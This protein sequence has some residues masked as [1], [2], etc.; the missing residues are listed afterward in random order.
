MEGWWAAEL[1]VGGG[2][3]DLEDGRVR[4]GGV[5]AVRGDV[6]ERG[7]GGFTG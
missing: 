5:G 2:A 6:E 3:S 4:D 1:H 7:G